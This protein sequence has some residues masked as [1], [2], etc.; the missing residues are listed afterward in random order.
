MFMAY[1]GEKTRNTVVALLALPV[2]TPHSG[3][4]VSARS[5][6]QHEP[7]EIPNPAVALEVV[8]QPNVEV[9]HVPIPP[10]LSFPS[11]HPA[12][13]EIGHDSQDRPLSDPHLGR[14]LA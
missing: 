11:Q 13:L 2:K 6:P 10:P 14:H 3:A 9:Q 4:A 1:L 12:R 7:Q 5:L 8:P